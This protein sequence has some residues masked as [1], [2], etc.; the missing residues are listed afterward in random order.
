MSEIP[1]VLVLQCKHCDYRPP[2][3]AVME[4]FQL[5]CQVE[6]DTDKLEMDLVVVCTC[7]STMKLV[8]TRETATGFVD[9][10]EC[11]HDGNRT[12]VRRRR[13]EAD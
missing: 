5:H 12:S 6:H 2:E 11:E 9:R 7:G 10:F 8:R 4:A 3:D 1:P 13:G